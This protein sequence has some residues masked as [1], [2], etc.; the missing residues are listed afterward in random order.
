MGESLAVDWRSFWAGDG[1]GLVEE[2]RGMKGERGR[3]NV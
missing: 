3:E 1:L 2:E